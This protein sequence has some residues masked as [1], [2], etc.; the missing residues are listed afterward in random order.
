MA[1]I[2]LWQIERGAVTAPAG[3]GKTY[4]IADALGRHTAPKPVL[5]LTHT[6]AGVAALRGRLNSASVP[7]SA[8]RLTTVDGWA[9]RLVKA[10]PKRSEINPAALDLRD[11]RQDYPAIRDAALRLLGNGHLHDV[12]AASY[13][14]LLVDEYQDCSARQHG[15]V[16]HAAAA[17]RTCVLGDPMQAV[18]GFGDPLADWDQVCSH[19]PLAG[20]LRTPHRWIRVGEEA[21]GRWLLDV[22][23]ALIQG[24]GLDLA[25]APANVQWVRLQG[26]QDDHRLR[27]QAARVVAPGAD[28]KV[29]IIADSTKPHVQQDFAKQTPG[30][31]TVE[32]VDLTALVAFADG[33]DLSSPSIL[34]HL[35]RFAGDV[36]T[37]VGSDDM[38][39][40]VNSLRSGRARREASASELAAIRFAEKPSYGGATDLL[41][42]I[43]KQ[44]GVRAHRPAILRGAFHVLNACK[45]SAGLSPSEAAITVREQSR[46]VGRPLAKRTVGSTLLLKGLEAE[47]SVVLNPELMDKRHLYVAIT[48]GSK[49]LV[50]CSRQQVLN[51]R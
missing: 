28:A 31:V 21:F 37:G 6:N 8:Y 12:L 2:D 36:M 48:R 25:A 15:I 33:F 49:Q 38:L 4:L 40:R 45:A 11:R 16:Y 42:E 35:V 7:S 29:L 44:G 27:L 39:Q 20:Q 32:N 10:F 1:E 9:M 46:L 13:D 43:S 50:I 30:A 19:F 17:L 23:E 47:T 3:C 14:R 51:P 34:P 41:A 24:R 18:F 22:R 5:I 26:S